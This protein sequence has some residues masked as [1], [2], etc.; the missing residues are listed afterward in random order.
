RR[1]TRSDRD[2]SSDVCS[3]DL[4]P[5]AEPNNADEIL[6]SPDSDRVLA[7]VGNYVYLVTLP[8][9]GGQTP[10]VNVSDPS[11]AAFPTK[12]LTR[13]G[14][15]F[16]G[17]TSDGRQAFWSIGRSFLKW[18]PA[19]ADSMDKVKA[20]ADSIRADSLKGDAFKALADSVQKRLKA[21][22]DSLSKQ[23]AYE[24]RR[25]DVAIRVPRDIPR[26]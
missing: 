4:G 21:R 20:R 16:I 11:S 17:W 24:P 26:G 1:H 14:G 6:I 13:I 15:D 25:V 22:S 18:D 23:P 2:W 10:V 3:S 9:I 5:G 12:R 8:L 19:V 7:Q